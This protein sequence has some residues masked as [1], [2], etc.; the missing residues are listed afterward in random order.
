MKL[1]ILLILLLTSI[2]CFGQKY[3]DQNHFY[4]TKGGEMKHCDSVSVELIPLKNCNCEHEQNANNKDPFAPIQPFIEHT[5]VEKRYTK[6]CKK[7]VWVSKSGEKDVHIWNGKYWI[8]MSSK[9]IYWYYYWEKY[10]EIL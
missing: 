3:W 10:T 2:T 9:G 4:H 6:H 5:C 1:Y 7:A 8:L